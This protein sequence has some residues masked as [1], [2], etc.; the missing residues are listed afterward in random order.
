MKFERLIA[1]RFLQKGEGNFTRPLVNI[2]TYSIALGVLVIIMSVSILRGFQNEITRKVVGFGSHI[3]VKPFE[4]Q[5][6]FY[7]HQPLA[8]DR[9][10]VSRIEGIEGV[11]HVQFFA[12]KGGM[13][14]TDEQIH[15]IVFKGVG[16]D[17]DSTF[18]KTNL[19]DGR[20]FDFSA[21]KAS[22]EII[23]SQRFS[24]KMKLKIGDKVRTY[25]WGGD[26][27]RARAFTIVGVYSTDLTEFDEKF[28]VGDMRHIQKINGWDSSQTAGY[29][30]LVDDFDNLDRIANDVYD[31]IDNS[32][33]IS[34]IVEDNPDMFSWLSLLDT[35]I[36]LI[37][38]VMM[39]V[40][41]VS[42][43]SAL[44]IMIFEKTPMIGLLKTMGATNGSIRRI[45]LYK[46]AGIIVKGLLIGNALA[47]LLCELQDKL[48]IVKLDSESYHMSA[49]PI[50][51]NPWIFVVLSAG[52]A[53]VCL[54][55]LLLPSSYIANIRPAKAIKVE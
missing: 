49:V 47:L 21:D 55:A 7:E 20:L 40:C 24:D 13:V 45:F 1:K 22:N 51:L 8:V 31:R 18:F 12:Q 26:N 23:V 2:A 15:G 48:Q 39:L 42:V 46:S 34:T 10:M 52:T 16:R 29:E 25:F 38:V 37:L 9:D 19:K 4:S 6:N 14:K 50:D 36:A 11:R 44:L 54:L 30:I 27:Y 3:V 53:A 17:F 32:L 33:T 41:I 5:N 28:I 35:D 43:I